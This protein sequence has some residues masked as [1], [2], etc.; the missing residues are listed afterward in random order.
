MG[1]IARGLAA[2]AVALLPQA[3]AAHPHV[4]IDAGIEAIFDADGRLSAVQVV[5]VYDEFYTMLS[6]DDYGMDPEFTGTVTE[7]E[8]AR[9]AAIYAN[10]DPGFNGDLRPI[11]DGREVAL[12]GPTRV[13]ADVRDA[14]LVIAHRRAFD[15]PLALEGHEMVLRVYDPGYFTA[16][17]IATD[18]VVTGRSDCTAEIRRPDRAAAEAEL[19]A[20][21]DDL[22]AQGTDPYALEAEF[23]AVGADFAEEVRLTCAGAS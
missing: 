8:R 11:L 13:V 3:A 6:L 2:A 1:R 17:T 21:L 23:P 20:A 15:P 5:W 7:A 4:F 16:Y 10:W 18:P 12:G 9:L 22:L 14:R 19:Q